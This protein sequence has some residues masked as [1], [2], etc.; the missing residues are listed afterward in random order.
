[1]LM[2]KLGKDQ[3]SSRYFE[4]LIDSGADYTMIPQSAGTILG[5][6]Y[7]SLPDHKTKIETANLESIEAK[8]TDLYL[9]IDKIRLKIP[10]LICK[11][12]VE[13]L[14]G[15]KGIFDNFEI[16]FKEKLQEVVFSY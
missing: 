2:A 12:E 6:T 15:R 4:F 14:L 10:V 11:E 16:T 7:K 3:N 1:M 9:T 5:L 13:C 8:Q